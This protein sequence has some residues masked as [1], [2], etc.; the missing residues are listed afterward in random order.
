MNHDIPEDRDELWALLGKARPVKASPAFARDV[1]RRVR[2]EQ[3]EREPGFF[4]WLRTGW[5]WVGFAG[6]VAAI[7]LVVLTSERS[8]PERA[9][10][11]AADSEGAAALA[12]VSVVNAEIDEVVESADFGVIA[13]LDVLLAMDENDVWLEAPAP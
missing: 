6:A 9:E 3:P 1:L 5:N 10:I 7:A 8:A 11:A 2:M 13:N 4:E 12:Q